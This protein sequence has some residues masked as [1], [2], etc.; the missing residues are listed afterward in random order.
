MVATLKWLAKL[1]IAILV[2]ILLVSL[3][4]FCQS[5]NELCIGF[6]QFLRGNNKQW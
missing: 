3:K 1:L 5:V 6:F 2:Y 4:A